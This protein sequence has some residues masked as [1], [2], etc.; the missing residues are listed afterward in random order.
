M[1]EDEFR[2][3]LKARRWNG[4]P[5]SS[6]SSRMSKARRFEKSMPALELGAAD[7]DAAFDA[8]GM[9]AVTRYL[10][11]TARTARETGSAPFELVG[12]PRTH[13]CG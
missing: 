2:A 9:E 7:L 1:K 12:G 4:K 5:L 8:D 3:W 10:R 11:N 13:P 6:I